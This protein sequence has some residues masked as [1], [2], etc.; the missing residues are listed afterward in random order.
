MPATATLPA[1]EGL[2]G[3]YQSQVLPGVPQCTPSVLQCAL[4]C[5]LLL[6][7]P[8][9]AGDPDLAAAKAYPGGVPLLSL[10]LSTLT[11]SSKGQGPHFC[12]TPG[13]LLGVVTQQCSG[14]GG[15][16]HLAPLSAMTWCV[17]VSQLLQARCGCVSFL[18]SQLHWPVAHCEHVCA[19]LRL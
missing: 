7:L 12:G 1:E 14:S 17:C 13:G 15:E 19:Y 6:L 16:D 5:H 2:C 8:D 4:G 11:C 18:L 10:L 3:A 9:A